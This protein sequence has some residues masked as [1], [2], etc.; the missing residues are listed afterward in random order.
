MQSCS[1][2]PIPFIN[3]YGFV[4]YLNQC[5]RLQS[6]KT[7]IIKS[8][9]DYNGILS[10]PTKTCKKRSICSD[11]AQLPVGILRPRVR[12]ADWKVSLK[13]IFSSNHTYSE[14]ADEPSVIVDGE[15]CSTY[16]NPKCRKKHKWKMFLSFKYFL[17][18]NLPHAVSMRNHSP[19]KLC[20][21]FDNWP[22]TPS[23][24]WPSNVR[25]DHVSYIPM[26]CFGCI[27]TVD[28]TITLRNPFSPSRWLRH[29]TNLIL[30]NGM[31]VWIFLLGFISIPCRIGIAEQRKPNVLP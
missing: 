11:P 3:S 28:V 14:F 2:F 29:M 19:P 12:H 5:C 26:Q 27:D 6:S 30:L 10:L 1:I 13:R 4:N 25:H 31:Y 21:F 23:S 9:L 20:T 18:I 17:R 22:L 8:P 16:F 24:S 7:F 15:Q